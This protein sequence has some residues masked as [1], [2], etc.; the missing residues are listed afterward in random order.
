MANSMNPDAI[1]I[2]YKINLKKLR[3]SVVEAQ[4]I[5]R[6]LNTS[7]VASSK[8]LG[9]MKVGVASASIKSISNASAELR[10]MGITSNMTAQQI[11]KLNLTALD[12]NRAF[13]LTKTRMNDLKKSMA[14]SGRASSKAAKE[15]KQLESRLPRLEHEANKG[16]KAFGDARRAMERW[17]GGFKYMMLSQAAWIASGAV[18]FG[19]LTAIS[20]AIKDFIDFHQDLR[21]TAAIVQA[22]T[23]GYEKMEKAAVKAFLNSTMSLKETTNALKILGQTGLDAAASAVVLETVYKIVTA[24]GADTTTTV[25]FLTTA[26]AVWRIEAE[27]AAAVGNVLGAALNFSKMEAEDLGTAF[28]YTA[29]LSKSLG[30]SYTDL[31]AIMAVMSN[32]GIKMST[33]ATGLRGIFAQLIASTPKFEKQILAAGLSMDAVSLKTNNFF[34]VLKT[35]E[36]AGFDVFKIFMGTR[37]RTGS[38]FTVLLEQG[39]VLMDLMRRALTD[40]NAVTVMFEKSMEGM[41]NQMI[42]TG[43]AI[44]MYMIDRLEFL[45]PILTGTAKYL[46]EVFTVLGELN[47]FI[48]AVGVAWGV[49]KL[50]A[51]AASIATVGL[52]NSMGF[53]AKSLMFLKTHWIFAAIAGLVLVYAGLKRVIDATTDSLDEQLKRNER[54]IDLLTKLQISMMDTR[55]TEEERLEL[56]AE[57]SDQY[58]ELLTLLEKHEISIDDINKA[59]QSLVDTDKRRN[60]VIKAGIL[61]QKQLALAEAEALLEGTQREG[62]PAG[63]IVRDP[64]RGFVASM[65]KDEETIKKHKDRIKKLAGE[66]YKLKL[67]LGIVKL[68]EIIPDTEE[69][70]FDWLPKHQKIL[71]KL[72][73]DASTERQQAKAD[74]IKKLKDVG[75]TEE[76]ITG[77]RT[78]QMEARI[79]IYKDY[80]KTISEIDEKENKKREAAIKKALKDEQREILKTFKQRKK[81]FDDEVKLWEDRFR[82]FRKSIKTR[83]SI[84]KK[85]VSFKEK[86]AAKLADQEATEYEREVASAQA[87]VDQRKRVYNDLLKIAQDYYKK[88]SEEA[89]GNPLLAGEVVNAA[90][91][92]AEIK[93]KL[94]DLTRLEVEV[95]TGIEKPIDV[96]DFA[97]GIKDGFKEAR[98]TLENEYEQWK[99]FT[100]EITL[101][102]QGSFRDIFFDA[103]TRDK[104]IKDAEK[105]AERDYKEDVDDINKEYAYKEET[106]TKEHLKALA[107]AQAEYARQVKDI[108]EEMTMSLGDYF[109]SFVVRVQSAIADLAA[110]WVASGLFGKSGGTGGIFGTI[111]S[112]G[113]AFVGGGGGASDYGMAGMTH[114]G[115]WIKR[116]HGGGYNLKSDESRRILKHGEYVIKDT[117]ASALGGAALDHMNRTGR[118]PDSGGRVVKNYNSYTIYAMDSE[119]MDQALRRGGARA[120]ADISLNSFSRESERLNPIT[121]R[122]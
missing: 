59:T 35:L 85:F 19:T 54:S 21:D 77:L 78:E 63:S 49:Y 121:R 24:T 81:V 32:A 16:A 116:M 5:L 2:E 84:E 69:K 67:D 94:S 65:S 64:R 41:K 75:Q 20:G 50:H 62:I 103:M 72:R 23:A 74:L 119:S 10:T 99:T 92:V 76:K 33:A 12:M 8:K 66:I 73:Y 43:H 105:Q 120:I 7:I 36:T 4:K 51:I 113:A 53:L 89:V 108:H 58:P 13:D 44:K 95:L 114:D 122:Y 22:T 1:G 3:A 14:G 28:N 9:Q 83:E 47:G 57:Y 17:G 31:A 60:A 68:P 102:V 30:L 46:R 112:A 56:L 79:I 61:I 110:S 93:A 48:L 117:S 38:A 96:G 40:T 37:R 70:K 88:M 39:S 52:A 6:G 115:G 111:L 34:D 87:R 109:D 15:Y 86:L 29:S 100:K 18:L 104:K 27:G 71:D 107:D 106:N 82:D 11:K 26:M 25:K 55:K 91:L 90:A 80:R 101:G 45:K 98:E 42:L 97:R 118:M